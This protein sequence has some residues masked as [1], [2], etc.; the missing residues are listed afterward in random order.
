[1]VADQGIQDF[2]IQFTNREERASV[3]ARLVEIAKETDARAIITISDAKIADALPKNNPELSSEVSALEIPE[4]CL[5]LTV[6][7]PGIQ[8]WAVSVPYC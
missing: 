6:S 5:Y 8:T 1:V 7:G 2:N 3:Y 4:D